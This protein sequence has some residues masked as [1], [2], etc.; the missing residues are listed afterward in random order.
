MRFRIQNEYAGIDVSDADFVVVDAADS[1]QVI[2]QALP[3]TV[4][5]AIQVLRA[6]ADQLEAV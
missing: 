1:D 2:D 4:A 3:D 6:Y 5:Q